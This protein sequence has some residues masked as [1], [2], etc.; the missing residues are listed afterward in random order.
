MRI[1]FDRVMLLGALAALA[2]LAGGCAFV[3]VPLALSGTPDMREFVVQPARGMFTRNKILLLD[4]SG[5]ISMEES[6]GLLRT[7]TSM[8]DDVQAALE[9]AREDGRI[10]AVILRIDSPGGE[11]TASD[12]IY[13]QLREF[14]RERARRGQ[15]VVV[16]ASILGEGASGGYYIA[17]AADKIYAHPTSITGSIGVIATFPNLGPLAQKLGVQMR[18]LKSADK[19]DL[20]SMWRDFSAE[21]RTILQGTIDGMYERF[22]GIVE[23]NRPDLSR[24]DVLRLADGR[25]YTA[26]QAL[27]HQLIDGIAYLDEVV[28][29]TREAAGLKDALIVT[30]RRESD[31]SGGLYSRLA[32]AAP[33]TPSVHL[34]EIHAGDLLPLRKPGFYYLWMP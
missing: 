7:R 10:R 27:E 1:S 14:K 12:L 34:I 9:K 28:V 15:P 24:E 26:Q 20:G 2:I 19:K 31:F 6:G 29:K 22:V 8:V 18:V 25:V 17:L 5:V 21:E 11:V 13:A 23:E 32:S 3:S 30:Y 33:R 4:L 16:T